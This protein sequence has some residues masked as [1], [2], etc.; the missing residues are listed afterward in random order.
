MNDTMRPA[1]PVK[2]CRK[3]GGFPVRTVNSISM[4]ELEYTIQC[5]HCGTT[6]STTVTFHL[7][8]AEDDPEIV[9]D[10]DNMQALHERWN[11]MN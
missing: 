4:F 9:Y 10:N 2:R 1:A 6:M 7:G 3:C 11:S 8:D 5:E